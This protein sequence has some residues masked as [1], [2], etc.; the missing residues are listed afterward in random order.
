MAT[1]TEEIRRFQILLGSSLLIS[2]LIA[3]F[4]DLEILNTWFEVEIEEETY[5]YYDG[6]T[7][8]SEQEIIFQSSE[9]EVTFTDSDGD[10]DD[11][12]LD[13]GEYGVF[14]EVEDV[15][16]NLTRL[17][18]LTVLAL[19]VLIWKLETFR[20]DAAYLPSIPGTDT[21]SMDNVS[22]DKIDVEKVEEFRKIAIAAIVLLALCPLY[23]FFSFPNAAE[24][25]YRELLDGSVYCESGSNA[26]AWKDEFEFK[27]SGKSEYSYDETLCSNDPYDRASGDASFSAG[28]SF[29]ASLL[30]VIPAFIVFRGLEEL[31]KPKLPFM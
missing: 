23:F 4:A 9:L 24:D 22:Q 15:M 12:T 16:K 3:G 1:T 21:F 11:Q 30:V 28:I 6:S 2:L 27:W 26:A 14:E 7:T 18:Y 8:N 17:L 19:G 10:S 13:Y 25:D 5:S 20:S 31:G 29:Y